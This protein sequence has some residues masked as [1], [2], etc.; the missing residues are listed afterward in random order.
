MRAIQ[1]YMPNPR[2]YETTRIF[3]NAKPNEAW[4]A[5]RHFNVSSIPWVNFLFKLRTFGD[6]IRND[7][8]SFGDTKKGMIDEIADHNE[9]FIILEEDPGT[10]VV[11]GA[12]GKFWHVNIPFMPITPKHFNLFSEPGWGKVAWSI[13]VEPYMTGSTI[14]FDLRTTATDQPGWIKLN[15]YYHVIGFFSRLIRHSLMNRLK[16]E[17]G[18]LQCPDNNSVA[19]PGDDIIA[20]SKYSDTD[21]ILIE[22]PLSIV[23]RYLMQLGCDRAGWYSIDFLDNDNKKSTDHI[24]PEW[25]DRNIGDR[26]SATP[27]N[28][29]FFEVYSIKK[30]D[31][32]VIGGQVKNAKGQFRS[33]WAFKLEPVGND[34]TFLITRARMKMSP[35]WK[36][37]IVGN[38]YYPI[39]HGIM[40]SVQLKTLRKYA[41]R[42]ANN[43]KPIQQFVV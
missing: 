43:R 2:H 26:I 18:K 17:L 27:E 38:L 19:L 32:F 40:E 35:Q 42:D 20:M 14:C 22:A 29:G 23:W 33:T 13:T 4:Q 41:E 15:R 11:I 31:H 36:E 16:A 10:S 1:K 7:K 39:A 8:P 12:I 24:V 37:L 30:E 9:G 3:V 28:D 34:A 25:E 21:K 5:I 6:I